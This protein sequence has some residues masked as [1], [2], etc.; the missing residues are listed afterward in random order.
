MAEFVGRAGL[1][2]VACYFLAVG[3]GLATQLAFAGG[4]II[5]RRRNM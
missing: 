2:F 1:M 3:V 4:Q 5:R